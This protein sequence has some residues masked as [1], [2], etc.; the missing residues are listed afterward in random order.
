ME[1]FKESGSIEY[2][3]D[4]LMGLQPHG[5]GS[6]LDEAKNEKDAE[7]KGRQLINNSKL[8][9]VRDVDITVLKNRWGRITGYG[10]G[11]HLVYHVIGNYFDE[12]VKGM[13]FRTT[14]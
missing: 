10:E 11:V 3:S 13:P 12:P 9:V 7:K 14:M 1:A 2:G 6:E 8:E 5:M 4:V